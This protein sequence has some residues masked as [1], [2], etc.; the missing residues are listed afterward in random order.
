MTDEHLKI[1]EKQ[2][3]QKSL[4]DDDNYGTPAKK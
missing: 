1:I 2:R 4:D 3:Q